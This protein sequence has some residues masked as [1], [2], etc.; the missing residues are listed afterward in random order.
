[1][2][3]ARRP[4]VGPMRTPLPWLGALLVLYLVVPLIAFVARIPGTDPA[5]MSAPGVGDALW[6]SV[7]TACISTA[8]ITILGVPLGYMLA[9]SK[10]RLS[11]IL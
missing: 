11:V 9:H 10:S 8:V 6:V 7:I 5:S 4:G 2:A 1:M 3:V